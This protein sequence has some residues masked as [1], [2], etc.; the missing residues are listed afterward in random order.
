MFVAD[1]F[2]N[3]KYFGKLSHNGIEQQNEL[4]QKEALLRN[5]L[6]LI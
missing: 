5:Q 3:F 2:L 4:K 1:I 6:P